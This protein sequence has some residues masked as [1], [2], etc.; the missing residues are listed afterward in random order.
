MLKKPDLPHFVVISKYQANSTDPIEIERLK[1]RYDV[2]EPAIRFSKDM[3]RATD[4]PR[5]NSVRSFRE[6][7]GKLEPEVR[8]LTDQFY[9]YALANPGGRK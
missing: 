5:Y 9:R 2:L 4:R 7:Y 6:K 3:T 8:A 1:K